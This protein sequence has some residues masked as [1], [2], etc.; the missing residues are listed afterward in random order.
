MEDLEM[1][2]YSS[3]H[4]EAQDVWGVPGGGIRELLEAI[5]GLRTVETGS[6]GYGL[7]RP[8]TYFFPSDFFS[9]SPHRLSPGGSEGFNERQADL[10]GI[11]SWPEVGVF[12]S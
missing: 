1:V 5:P 10:L 8:V 6:T 4:L 7:E 2:D 11:S 12:F 3:D 9:F